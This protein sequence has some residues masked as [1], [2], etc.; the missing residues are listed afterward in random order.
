M[1]T[2]SMKKI[3]HG[4]YRDVLIFFADPSTHAFVESSVIRPLL[5]RIFSSMYPYI[6][7]VLLLWM[8]MFTCLIVI[9]LLVVRR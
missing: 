6:V 8:L 9:L 2:N 5:S 3:F 4:V 1:Y 7:G